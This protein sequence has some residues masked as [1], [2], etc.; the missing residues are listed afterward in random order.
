M[1]AGRFQK[2]QSGNPKGRPR[3]LRPDPTTS[4]FD[5]IIDKTLTLS[6]DGKVREV[7]IEEA[8]QHKTYQEAI[9]GSRMARRQIL[10]MIAKREQAIA[11]RQP[12]QRAP[13]T[14]KI[15]RTDP[16]NADDALLL[17]GIATEVPGEGSSGRRLLLEPWAVQAALSRRSSLSL[18]SSDVTDIRRSTRDPDCVRGLVA[19][20]Q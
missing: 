16:D 1:S 11:A 2:G 19:N 7:T 9:A 12:V 14:V 17:L 13:V 15:E 6:R 5:I 8:L 4:A 20:E 10:R 18:K 3:K